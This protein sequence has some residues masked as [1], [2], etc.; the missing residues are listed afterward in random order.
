M[1]HET[2]KPLLAFVMTTQYSQADYYQK[3]MSYGQTFKKRRRKVINSNV[4]QK[5]KTS[6]YY[7]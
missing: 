6:D 1:P 4:G 3:K 5:H 7:W 2:L